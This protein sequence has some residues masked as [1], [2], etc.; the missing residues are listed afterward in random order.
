MCHQKSVDTS[1]FLSC[2]WR[3]YPAFSISVF[4]RCKMRFSSLEMYDCEMP[5]AS[6]TSFCVWLLLPVQPKPQLHDLLFARVKLFN[7]TEQRLLFRFLLDA[8]IHN[9]GVAA[10]RS[11][12]RSSLPSQSTFSGSSS[13]ISFFSCAVLRRYIR[14]SF[15]MHRE[16]YVASL[17]L[18]STLN[19]F[20]ALMSPMV[21]MEMRSSSSRQAIQIF[22]AMYTT[23][24]RLCVIRGSRAFGFPSRMF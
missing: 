3:V 8:A 19:V 9:V 23:S 12:S 13:E 4:N 2:L 14:I 18:R 6:A 1:A 21:P 11:E 16:A 22:S 15:S 24:R 20:T 10:S 17:M 5:S 7:G